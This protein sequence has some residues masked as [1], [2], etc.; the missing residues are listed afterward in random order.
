MYTTAQKRTFRSKL[1]E[2]LDPFGKFNSEV[3]RAMEDIKKL[4]K[5]VR[6]LV[7]GK[8]RADG[9]FKSILKNIKSNLNRREYLVAV[10]GLSDF[11][12][13]FKEIHELIEEFNKGVYK[14]HEQFLYQ[15][16]G[17]KHRE[18]ILRLKSLIE[19]D[20]DNKKADDQTVKEAGLGDFIHNVFSPKGRALAAYEKRYPGKASKLKEDLLQLLNSSQEVYE[21]M[22]DRLNLMDSAI[23][24]SKVGDYATYAQELSDSFVKYSQKFS[25]GIKANKSIIS[26]L[27]KYEKKL[28][29]ISPVSPAATEVNT[30]IPDLE[31]S[32]LSQSPSARSTA[33]PIKQDPTS[34][35]GSVE[36]FQRDQLKSTEPPVTKEAP[37]VP[38]LP[39]PVK[40]EAPKVETSKVEVP[41]IEAPKVEA[42]KVELPEDTEKNIIP[43][44]KKVEIGSVI[45]PEKP[46]VTPVNKLPVKKVKTHDKFY[47]N[48][49]I[50]QGQDKAVIANYIKRYAS[51]ISETDLDTSKRLFNIVNRILG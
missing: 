34:S 9:S 35:G 28:N 32:T 42:P 48:L 23:G 6:E 2:K 30:N 4:D 46:F 41:K 20:S 33:F 14:A 38:S 5:K 11:Y 27:E 19:G 17:D 29:P 31:P 36:F 44:N 8:T 43:Q 37:T 15:D 13:Y 22:V 21:F 45:P 40:T 26:D 7:L 16:V 10:A 3:R 24:A 49:K 25:E 50:L 39:T 12:Y 47:N 1:R 51:E 18:K